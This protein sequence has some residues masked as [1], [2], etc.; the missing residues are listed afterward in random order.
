MLAFFIVFGCT[1]C[2]QDLRT[3]RRHIGSKLTVKMPQ[4]NTTYTKVTQTNLAGITCCFAS[5]FSNVTIEWE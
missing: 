1:A 4:Q 2:D 3:I 5:G